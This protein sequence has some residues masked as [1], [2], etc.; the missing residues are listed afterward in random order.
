MSEASSYSRCLQ[1]VKAWLVLDMEYQGCWQK[2]GNGS[3]D[4]RTT[5]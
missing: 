1:R 2:C 4:P 5:R 3:A